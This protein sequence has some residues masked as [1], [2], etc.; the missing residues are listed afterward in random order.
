MCFPRISTCFKRENAI[1]RCP[2]RKD[3]IFTN[4]SRDSGILDI[5][6]F[7]CFHSNGI[8]QLCVNYVNE[9]LQ[10]YFVEKYLVSCRNNLQKEG[11]IDDETPSEIKQSYEDRINTLEKYLFTDLND[12]NIS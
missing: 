5:F 2:A 12:V 8:E 7:E 3:V 6:G 4:T 10:Q 9:R 1:F 11:L